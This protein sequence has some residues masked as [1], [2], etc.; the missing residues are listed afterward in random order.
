MAPASSAE[1]CD[2]PARSPLGG[3]VSITRR[4]SAAGD[5]LHASRSRLADK[6]GVALRGGEVHRSACNEPIARLP[7]AE[8]KDHVGLGTP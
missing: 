2:R 7:R 4:A 3:R 1:R 5:S 6:G 8:P